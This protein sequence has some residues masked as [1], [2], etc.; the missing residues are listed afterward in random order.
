MPGTVKEII[1]INISDLLTFFMFCHFTQISLL[2]L[3]KVKICYTQL[4]RVFMG[5]NAYVRDESDI[6]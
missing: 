6:Y 3:S 5:N 2:Y 4:V 1:N